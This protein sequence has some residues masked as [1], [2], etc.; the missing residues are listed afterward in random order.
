MLFLICCYFY[1]LLGGYTDKPYI[2]TLEFFLDRFVITRKTLIHTEEYQN[3][4]T[5]ESICFL[6]NELEEHF[7]HPGGGFALLFG[8]CFI[9]YSK[10]AKNT[11]SSETPMIT[12]DRDAIS[13]QVSEEE[14]E[15]IIAICKQY[16]YIEEKV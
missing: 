12:K 1:F 2:C 8:E 14:F 7:Y 15:K 4:Y 10:E 13:L 11:P 3:G 6:Y 16:G 5:K 9:S